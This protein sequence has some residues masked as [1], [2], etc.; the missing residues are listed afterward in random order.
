MYLT[1]VIRQPRDGESWVMVSAGLERTYA[2]RSDGS[3][4]AWGAERVHGLENVRARPLWIMDGV[5]YVSAGGW[6]QTMVIKTDGS[7]WSLGLNYR[8]RVE[9]GITE[10]HQSLRRVMDDVVAV[11]V[12][13]NHT[14]AIT[15]DGVLWGWGL[16][17]YIGL[18]I[19]D[20]ENRMQNTPVKV[21]EDVATV[22]AG[23]HHA[24]AVTNDGSLWAWGSFAQ[25]GDGRMSTSHVPI[26]IMDDVVS[27]SV[28]LRHTMAIRTDGSL[29]GWGEAHGSYPV[30]IMDDVASVSAGF[31]ITMAV[32]EDGSLWAWGLNN[33]SQ[34]GIGFRGYYAVEGCSHNSV[35]VPVMI[36]EGV[37]DVSVG[38]IGAQGANRTH[39]AAVGTDGS[40]WT[41]GDNRRGQLGTGTWMPR[42]TP[43]RISG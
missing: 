37:A 18:E 2:V 33:S 19:D 31:G 3:L 43:V 23:S 41:W 25:L 20:S 7:L 11:S 21:M 22:S 42:R 26:W 27:V 4:W 39:T 35:N 13:R 40:L 10:E 12:G 29:W 9:G 17:D 5:A 24:V 30:K 14:M 8:E 6:R 15:S 38:G 28:G 16:R 32:K 34:L 1:A 36:L